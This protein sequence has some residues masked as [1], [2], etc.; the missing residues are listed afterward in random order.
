MQ[1]SPAPSNFRLRGSAA[2]ASQSVDWRTNGRND[3]RMVVSGECNILLN[4]SQLV[5]FLSLRRRRVFITE[6][7]SGR[8]QDEKEMRP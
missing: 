3:W 6:A 7:L 5:R 1:V 2:I 4:L 8:G